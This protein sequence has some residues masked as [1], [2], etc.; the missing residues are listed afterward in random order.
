MTSPTQVSASSSTNPP[1]HVLTNCPPAPLERNI[2]E[3]SVTESIV[4]SST[5]VISS[6]FPHAN[7][8][9]ESSS[10]T[11][12]PNA[13]RRGRNPDLGSPESLSDLLLFTCHQID[14]TRIVPYRH[15]VAGHGSRTRNDSVS[16]SD[17]DQL[18]LW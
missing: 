15:Q 2:S 1:S 14:P 4:G 11:G 17:S 6:Q 8:T 7:S 9:T 18:F 3:H 12:E 5:S 10:P 13:R 16:K